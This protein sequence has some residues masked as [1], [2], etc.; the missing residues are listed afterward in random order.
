VL[1]AALCACDSA[2]PPTQRSDNSAAESADAPADFR[3]DREYPAIGYA[4][5]VPVD[6]LSR[7]AGQINDGSVTLSFDAQRGYLDAVLDALDIDPSSQVLVFSRTSLQVEGVT[8]ASPRAIYFS[9]DLYVAWVPGAESIELAA[10][11]A[12]LGPVFYTLSQ[13]PTPAA[14]RRVGLC[15]SCHDSY[16]MTGGGVPRFITGSGYTGKDGT[17]VAHEGWILTSDR[18]PLRSRWGGWYVSGMHGEQVHLGNIAV[19]SVYDLEDLESLRN[20]NHTDLTGLLDVSAYLTDKSDIVALLVLEH[21]VTVQNAIVRLN[22]DAR[23]HGQFDVEPLV[24]ALL[25]AGTPGFTDPVSGTAGFEAA[26]TARGARDARGR[27][28]REFD[29]DSRLFRYPL[30]YVIYSPAFAALPDDVLRAVLL[31][32]AAELTG[33]DMRIDDLPGDAA[34]RAAAWEILIDTRPEFAAMVAVR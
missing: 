18:T 4:Q 33:T 27:S 10:L 8:A 16:S 5:R 24:R 17:I 34:S 3:Y 11:D 7:I 28:L 6:P 2:A 1:T 14:E 25:F 26:F 20:G 19:D 15:L 29:L 23:Q 31:R 22:W 9:D 12:G 13:S 32:V 21:Q 30:S